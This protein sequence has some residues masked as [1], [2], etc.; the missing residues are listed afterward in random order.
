VEYYSFFYHLAGHRVV[1]T[2][3]SLWKKPPEA[4]ARVASVS[5]GFFM[6][7]ASAYM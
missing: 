4:K 3:H 1:K 5:G 6:K 2:K 7:S